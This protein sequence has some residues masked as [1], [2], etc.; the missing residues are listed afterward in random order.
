MSHL[1]VWTAFPELDRR[2]KALKVGKKKFEYTPEMEKLDEEIREK[3]AH[4]SFLMP[5]QICKHCYLR[6]ETK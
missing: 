1:A 6:S 2:F 3:Y 4:S 5:Y